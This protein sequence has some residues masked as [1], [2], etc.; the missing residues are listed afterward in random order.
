MGTSLSTNN[1]EPDLFLT[2]FQDN[3]IEEIAGSQT[4]QTNLKIRGVNE[5]GKKMLSH[6]QVDFN[7]VQRN[8]L[9]KDVTSQVCLM[10]L[11]PLPLPH[12]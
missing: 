5:M 11:M 2:C 3:F 10:F 6:I 12:R 7:H 8:S 1:C 4:K 9:E